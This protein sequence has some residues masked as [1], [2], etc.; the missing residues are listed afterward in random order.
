M[1]R[2]FAVAVLCLL[3]FGI[4]KLIPPPHQPSSLPNIVGQLAF[5]KNACEGAVSTL[6]RNQL[7]PQNQNRVA[8]MYNTTRAHAEAAITSMQ[9]GLSSGW[10]DASLAG[11]NES[12]RQA[13]HGCND[14]LK[15][16]NDFLRATGSPRAASEPAIPAADPFGWL[17]GFLNSPDAA[18][19]LYDD[20]QKHNEQQRAELAVGF[21]KLRWLPL[22]QL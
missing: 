4:Y 3:V 15:F 19:R 10:S 17:P 14:L 1:S 21:L 11:L 7:D 2:V 13:N 22:E 9:A 20:Y 12:L 18:R 16:A 8:M 5:A 6:K